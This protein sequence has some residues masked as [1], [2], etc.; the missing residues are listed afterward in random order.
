M[1]DCGHGNAGRIVGE[2]A[3]ANSVHGGGIFN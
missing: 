1:N 2:G 3:G